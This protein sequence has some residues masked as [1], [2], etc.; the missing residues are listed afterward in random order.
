MQH[1]V[2]DVIIVGAGFAGLSASYYLK[3]YGLN[4]II[5]ERGRVGESWRSQ[6]WDS[7][8]MNSTNK[9][10]VLPGITWEDTNTA[11]AFS[12]ASEL[13]CSFEQYVLKHQ[14]PV[15]E[16]SKVISVE[17][18]SELFCVAVLSNGQIQN[19]HCRQVLIASGI[20]NEIKLPDF[21]KNLSKGI[22]QLHTSEYRNATLLPDGAV[23]VVGGAQSGCQIAEDLLAA[24]RKVFLSTSR[25]GRF[26][27]WYRGKD[28]FDWLIATK[29][30]EIKA[31]QVEDPKFFEMRNPQ[32]S[33]TGSGRDSLSLQLLAR[34]GAT[35]LG[36]MD[37]A[38]EQNVFF[39]SNAADHVKYADEFSS[40][41]KKM[42]DDFIMANDLSVPAAHYD[43]ADL[44]DINGSCASSVTS[45]NL[46]EDNINTVIWSTGFNVDLS[47]VKLPLFD[48]AG[49]LIQKDGIPAVPGLYFLGYPW[50]FNRKS[51]IL[52]G[53]RDDVKVIV[54]KI[55]NHFKE[56]P[57][58]PA[59]V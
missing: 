5:F 22:N 28:I 1:A 58:S 31:E 29:F 34:N 57:Q 35:I 48:A 30:Y 10:N 54:D 23:L 51:T 15:S 46:A 11:E 47:Y 17:K 40:K 21:S 24:R 9:L 4:H 39:Q 37:H 16:N 38:H 44:P 8:R 55:F 12:T 13:V 32:I 52:F 53:I 33:G 45:L 3:K 19:Y 59:M 27:R 50:L 7:F 20:A 41:I 2:S 43:E 14:L 6:R 56:T 18:P 49:K 25:V 36:K 42:I 26:P